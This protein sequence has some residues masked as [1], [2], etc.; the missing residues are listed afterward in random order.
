MIVPMAT[1]AIPRGA[2]RSLSSYD[3][4]RKDQELFAV[5]LFCF[6]CT[7]LVGGLLHNAQII[8][9]ERESRK[10]PTGNPFI[11]P[12][13]PYIQRL[14]AVPPERWVGDATTL[15]A[16]SIRFPLAHV[17]LDPQSAEGDLRKNH[18]YTSVG[19]PLQQSPER[20]SKTNL[21]A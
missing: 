12:L 20:Q 11:A 15:D 3:R 17:L 2:E 18:R 8:R 9:Q 19:L 6:S 14:P 10:H 4:E 1:V 21:P 5:G 16:A 13:P 7:L